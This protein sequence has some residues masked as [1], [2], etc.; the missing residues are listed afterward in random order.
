MHWIQIKKI[1]KCRKQRTGSRNAEQ[2]PQ[3]R[4]RLFCRCVKVSV[5]IKGATRCGGA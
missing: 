5:T 4:A 1:I 3:E 2:S